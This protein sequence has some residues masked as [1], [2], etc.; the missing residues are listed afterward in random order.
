MKPLIVVGACCTGE[1]SYS[2][3]MRPEFKGVD[4][5]L[6]APN[7]IP[8]GSTVGDDRYRCFYAMAEI[9]PRYNG[10]R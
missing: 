7:F 2:P 1:G 8:A 6:D 10:W 9:V 4:L 3:Y 5:G